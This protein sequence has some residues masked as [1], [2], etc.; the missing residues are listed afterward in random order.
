MR[1]AATHVEI[2]TKYAIERR[3]SPKRVENWS[4]MRGIDVE[5]SVYRVQASVYRVEA[6][7]YR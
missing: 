2:G 1:Y 6:S 4:V 5:A 3:M 7:V